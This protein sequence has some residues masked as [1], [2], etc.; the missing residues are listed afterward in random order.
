MEPVPVSIG[1]S[2]FDV[3]SILGHCETGWSYFSQTR[4]C[5]RTLKNG[6]W[7][8]AEEDCQAAGAHLTSIHSQAENEFVMQISKEGFVAND[9]SQPYIGLHRPNGT[10][11]WTDG[12]VS[13]Y[14]NWHPGR[15]RTSPYDCAYVFADDYASNGGWLSSWES[16]SCYDVHRAFVCKKPAF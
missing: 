12:S 9:A 15:P 16:G 8:T 13:N 5:Y 2:N 14:T 6:Y 1:K 11:I 7:Y 10:W 3:S 4:S